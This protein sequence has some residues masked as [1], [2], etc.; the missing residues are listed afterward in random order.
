MANGISRET[1]EAMEDSSKLNVL[2]DY[3]K[4]NHRCSCATEEKLTAL[5]HKFD[6]RKRSDA[7]MSAGGG[8]VGGFLA[9]LGVKLGG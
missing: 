9:F 6:H 2:F 7:I 1:F 3:L 5:E 8:F 4:E